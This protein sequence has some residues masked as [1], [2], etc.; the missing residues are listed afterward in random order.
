MP[1]YAWS[2]HVCGHGAPAG[3]QACPACHAPAQLSGTEI[4]ER[5]RQLA[6]LPPRPAWTLSPRRTGLIALGAYLALIGVIVVMIF[7]AGGDMSGLLIVIPALP[8]PMLG[9]WLLGD[10]GFGI[11][12][13]GGLILNGALAYFAGAGLA[14]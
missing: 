10:Y 1:A 5:K 13:V 9:A 7:R 8:W 14:R 4:D 6:A 2:C 11:G 3:T 12:V